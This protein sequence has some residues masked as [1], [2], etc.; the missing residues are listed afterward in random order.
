MNMMMKNEHFAEAK[1][2][3]PKIVLRRVQAKRSKMINMKTGTRENTVRDVPCV[4][5]SKRPGA[6][7]D[8]MR[9][10]PRRDA[11]SRFNN[12]NTIIVYAHRRPRPPAFALPLLYAASIVGGAGGLCTYFFMLL[13]EYTY[14]HIHAIYTHIYIYIQY[15]Y[16]YTLCTD[17]YFLY[18]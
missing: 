18:I 5:P 9:P 1:R 12:Y 14:I 15:I 3:V 10:D 2:K 6:F 13:Y 4:R 17:P 7:L 8:K 16:M 11:Y